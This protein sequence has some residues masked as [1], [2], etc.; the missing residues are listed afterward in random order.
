MNINN[1]EVHLLEHVKKNLLTFLSPSLIR[2]I[3]AFHDKWYENNRHL[4]RSSTFP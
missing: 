2:D 4:R 3:D 1:M